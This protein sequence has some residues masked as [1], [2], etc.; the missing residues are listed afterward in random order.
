MTDR[1]ITPGERV[2]VVNDLGNITNSEG[3]P[4]V[5][6]YQLALNESGKPVIFPQN[7]THALKFVGGILSGETGYIKGPTIKTTFSQLKNDGTRPNDDLSMQEHTAMI[8]VFLD[9]YQQLVYVPS[10]NV[11][12][13]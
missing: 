13:F 2:K 9:R 4:M 5:F 6:V 7:N 12:L 10:D 3:K 8:P 11:R 1:R